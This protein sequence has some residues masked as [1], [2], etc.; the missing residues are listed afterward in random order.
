MKTPPSPPKRK[1][2]RTLAIETAL[3][4]LENERRYVAKELHDGV[5]QTTLQ[6]GLQAGICR[7]LLERGNLEMLGQELVAL[8]GRLQ[9]ASAQVRDVIADMRPPRLEPEAPVSEYLQSAI[10]THR[11]RGGAP[12]EV[13]LNLPKRALPFSVVQKLTLTRIVQ[14]ALLNIR[15]HARAKHVRLRLDADSDSIYLVIADDGQ[16]FDPAEI[17]ALPVDRRG[18]GLA[19]LR[20][21]TEALGG[22][23]TIGRNAAGE[24]T[25]VKV[26]WPK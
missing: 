24:W 3:H 7:K 14:E 26:T 19:N 8:E 4:V 11:E 15:K 1:R 6:L 21:R 10:K 5:A 20:V 18:A 23:L 13:Q 25:E 22:T 2:K 17:E 12:V 9:L 16:G